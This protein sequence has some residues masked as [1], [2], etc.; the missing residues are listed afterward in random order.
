MD[1]QILNRKSLEEFK[2]RVARELAGSIEAIVVYGSV[3][4]GE[5]TE[6]SDIDLLIV[7]DEKEEIEDKVLEITYDID[8]KNNTVTTRLYLTPEEMEREVRHGSPFIR[9]V[10]AQGVAL[11]D[12]GTFRRLREE[13]FATSR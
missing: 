3:A 13:V 4:R 10:L 8:L 2:G 9:D 1:P 11:Y 12:N 6:N 5:A 7:S